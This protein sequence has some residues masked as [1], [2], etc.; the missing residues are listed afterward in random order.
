L[1]RVVKATPESIKCVYCGGEAKRQ[2]PLGVMVN[3]PNHFRLTRKEQLEMVAPSPGD[4]H[5]WD[6]LVN[7]SQ[8]HAPKQLT[9]KDHLES[10]VLK[11]ERIEI[12]GSAPE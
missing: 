9:L 8:T 10:T 5:G 2:F 4:E 3:I 1:E 7:P 12:S 11:R 6:A